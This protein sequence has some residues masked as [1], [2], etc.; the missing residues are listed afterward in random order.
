MAIIYFPQTYA[1]APRQNVWFR[2]WLN[3]EGESGGE[4]HGP[5][6]I[7]ALPT[8]LHQR[9]AVANNEIESTA[10]M[11]DGLTSK[12]FYWYLI[13]NNNDFPVSFRVHMLING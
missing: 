3:G 13:T 2:C 1:I 11:P 6:P 10:R 9:L 12:V 5:A 4:Y 8:A 7:A